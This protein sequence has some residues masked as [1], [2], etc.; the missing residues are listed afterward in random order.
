MQQCIGVI[1][2]GDAALILFDLH[3]KLQ[4]MGHA[5]VQ[6]FLGKLPLL[7]RLFAGGHIVWTGLNQIHTRRQRTF[8]VLSGCTP[9]ADN[10]TVEVQFPAQ[11]ICQQ[12]FAI[13]GELSVHSVVGAHDT[14]D[15]TILDGCLKPTGIQFHHNPF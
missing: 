12:L 3:D 5:V 8:L 6:N 1:L 10:G 15:V 7:H 4:D 14:Q 13:R 9:V 11:Q 2:R